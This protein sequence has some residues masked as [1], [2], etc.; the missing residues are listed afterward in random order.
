[1]ISTLSRIKL[2]TL[3]IIFSEDISIELT[4]YFYKVYQTKGLLSYSD[5]QIKPV[6]QKVRHRQNPCALKII[7]HFAF[8]LLIKLFPHYQMI[9]VR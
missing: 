7:I 6:T 4:Y 8:M 5:N 1:M 9:A 3:I 2:S